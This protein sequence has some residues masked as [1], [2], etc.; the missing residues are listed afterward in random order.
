MDAP[1]GSDGASIT[2]PS[3]VT[4][5]EIELLHVPK[6]NITASGLAFILFPSQGTFGLQPAL[7]L[8]H[9]NAAGERPFAETVY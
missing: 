2:T 7:S 9:Q 8:D 3:C 4:A 6:S 5:R 1:S